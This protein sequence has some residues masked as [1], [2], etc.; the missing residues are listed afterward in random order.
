MRKKLGGR[1]VY[2][3]LEDLWI[4]SKFL[5]SNMPILE[6]GRS[7][8]SK[9]L[10]GKRKKRKKPRPGKVGVDFKHYNGAT[11][12]SAVLGDRHICVD[13]D[14]VLIPRHQLLLCRDV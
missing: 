5:R 10:R 6:V 9:N 7:G 11:D 12:L 14:M 3:A 13:T 1:R 2:L 8:E 4:K